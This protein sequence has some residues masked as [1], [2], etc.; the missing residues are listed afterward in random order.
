MLGRGEPL[1]V[2]TSG[3][4]DLE[5]R[6]PDMNTYTLHTCGPTHGAVTVHER[7]R[8]YQQSGA[9][10]VRVL[11]LSSEVRLFKKRWQRAVKGAKEAAR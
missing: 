7:R 4:A 10:S 3:S 1:H 11:W 8:V 9:R 5:S 6:N 2:L